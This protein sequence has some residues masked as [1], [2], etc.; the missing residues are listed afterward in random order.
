MTIST[1]PRIG[2]PELCS[3]CDQTVAKA[4]TRSGK[5]I[6]MDF[7]PSQLGQFVIVDEANGRCVVAKAARYI[8][9]DDPRA[10]YSCHWNHCRG[11]NTN[12]RRR[13]GQGAV[14]YSPFAS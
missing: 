9:P 13:Y 8:G 1:L 7:H 5:T 12:P 11:G 10:R 2:H 6:L 14:N 3:R 4:T